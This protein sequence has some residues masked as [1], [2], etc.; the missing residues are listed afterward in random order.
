MKALR[1]KLAVLLLL[2][3]VAAA[4]ALASRP[5]PARVAGKS[6]PEW[7]RL[8]AR[9][10]RTVSYRSEGESATRGVSGHFVLNQGTEG[11][12]LLQVR[13][14]HGRAC[15][16]GFDGQVAWYETKQK[17]AKT[18]GRD[19]P[20]P[21]HAK[22]TLLGETEVAGRPAVRLLVH[23]GDT[24]KDLALDAR[25]GVILAMTTRFRGKEISRLR[26]AT[27]SYRPVTL[28]RCPLPDTATL[29]EATPADV[30]R[31]VGEKTLPPAWLP[32]GFI[33][34]RPV[35]HTCD[36]CGHQM[37]GLRYADG[38]RSLTLLETHRRNSCL[39]HGCYLSAGEGQ[40]TATR[41]VGDIA[42]IAVGDLDQGTLERVLG[43]LG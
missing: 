11:K 25:T 1:L 28:R 30:H 39:E 23:A 5:A 24:H 18:S 38:L 32:K 2:A 8:A 16:L 20:L 13:D 27:I 19:A 21:S 12:Y 40:V 26:T 9:A 41:V 3:A 34:R 10:A 15:T 6:A 17:A 22:A 7:L 33:A 36:C 35:V 29:P 42:V 43:S 31:L 4:G 14:A 37:I